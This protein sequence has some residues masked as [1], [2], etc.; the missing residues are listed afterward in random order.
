M[1]KKIFAKPYRGVG[2]Q[3]QQFADRGMVIDIPVDEAA[4]VLYRNFHK[5]I[6]VLLK[7]GL[8]GTE[9]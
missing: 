9:V 7:R 3:V 8:E 1:R 5:A 2:E 4:A 6:S